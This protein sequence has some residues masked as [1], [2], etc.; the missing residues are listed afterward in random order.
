MSERL[1]PAA[2][3]AERTL[4]TLPDRSRTGGL[5]VFDPSGW[6]KSR[7][8]GRAIAHQDFLR[9]VGTVVFDVV[10]ATI[11]N[12]LDKLLYLPAGLQR[13]ALERVRYC[14]MAGQRAADARVYVPAFPMLCPQSEGESLFITAQR[15]WWI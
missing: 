8:L 4:V 10:G 15:V 7:L 2:A 9:G 3:G 6:G 1:L 13:A 11:D 12:A 5:M 14:N